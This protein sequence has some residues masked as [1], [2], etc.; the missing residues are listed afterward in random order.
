[1]KTIRS[2][3]FTSLTSLAALLLAMFTLTSCRDLADTPV[4]EVASLRVVHAVTNAPAFNLLLNTS[5]LND[6]SYAFLSTTTPNLNSQNPI[7]LTFTSTTGFLSI[8]T[9]DK[10]L[11]V[12]NATPRARPTNGITSRF[13]TPFSAS[14]FEIRS[15][16]L[17]GITSIEA[18]TVNDNQLRT[19]L[20]TTTANGLRAG[21][22]AI[23]VVHGS[24]SPS[25]V[26]VNLAIRS[27]RASNA[28]T[29]LFNTL[30]PRSA[31]EFST[32]PLLSRTSSVAA[33]DSVS[34]FLIRS[35]APNDTLA[36]LTNQV[37]GSRRVYTIL[38]RGTID[39]TRA[40]SPAGFGATL[41]I[42]R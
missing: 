24:I 8:R 35:N 7:A 10:L 31:T 1:M 37:L 42:D 41:L 5:R 20:D 6:T 2:I 11:D 32:Q 21:Q 14:S 17:V 30:A 25:P 9:G 39:S 19:I 34:M 29:T 18:L 33:S 22:Y 13:T 4:D 26:S 16:F 28:G 12:F 36:R 38:V 27:V 40:G 15:I 3:Q 23:R